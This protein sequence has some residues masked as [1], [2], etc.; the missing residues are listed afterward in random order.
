MMNFSDAQLKGLAVTLSD[1]GQVLLATVVIPFLFGLQDIDSSA[2]LFGFM[3]TLV[4]WFS[5]IRLLK[6]V[7]LR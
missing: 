1:T 5:S 6:E 3:V 2:M 4:C 7:G